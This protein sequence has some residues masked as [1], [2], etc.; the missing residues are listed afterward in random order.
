[1]ELAA[2]VL[3]LLEQSLPAAAQK[4]AGAGAA[5]GL[6][7]S[8]LR[9]AMGLYRLSLAGPL[10][11]VDYSVSSSACREA[12]QAFQL[13][14]LANFELA[15]PSSPPAQGARSASMGSPGPHT[16]SKAGHMAK[17]RRIDP[18]QLASPP[19]Q[20]DVLAGSVSAGQLQT[21]PRHDW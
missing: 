21:Q 10:L 9:H 11:D 14:R 13:S 1:M 15:A 6:L 2:H 17:K 3:K 12:S 16:G 4:D 19:A 8:A 20:L 7:T 5:G 18:Q